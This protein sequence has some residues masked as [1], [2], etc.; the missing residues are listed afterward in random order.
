MPYSRGECWDFAS[1]QLRGDWERSIDQTANSLCSIQEKVIKVQFSSECKVR[2]FA[3]C[4]KNQPKV[5]KC[6]FKSSWVLGFA[7]Y[8]GLWN[9]QFAKSQFVKSRHQP[10]VPS[11][12][13]GK[14]MT[15]ALQIKPYRRFLSYVFYNNNYYF[16][17]LKWQN[18]CNFKGASLDILFIL[19]ER[20]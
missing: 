6:I 4:S 20:K 10:G 16:W 7:K 1:V 18:F 9:A 11:P 15:S 2:V 17:N 14:P 5:L 8:C 3:N 13:L 12:P 19:I